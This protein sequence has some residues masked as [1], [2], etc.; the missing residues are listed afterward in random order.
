MLVVS[1]EVEQALELGLAHLSE[2]HDVQ[3]ADTYYP[4]LLQYVSLLVKWNRVYNLTAIREPCAMVQRHLMDSLV[5]CR[6]LPAISR[7][8][9][10][11]VDVVDIGSGAGLPVLPL[12]IVRP[13]LIF[14]SIESNGK[15]TR[16]QQQVLVELSIGNVRISNQRVQDVSLEA[17]FVT[18]R[19]FTAPDA[20]LR[21][22]TSLCSNQAQVAIMLAHS[23]KLPEPLPDTF[24]LQ[25]LVPV[26]IPGN[27]APRHIAMC[28]WKP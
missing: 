12:A 28:R 18:S 23:D 27:S 6:W 7:A 26:D 25:E 14:A 10:T 17:D 2:H 16:F 8:D 21:I 4:A 15:K 24:L 1:A 3:I 5:L 19:A 22:A 11:R 20:F 9:E 13:D